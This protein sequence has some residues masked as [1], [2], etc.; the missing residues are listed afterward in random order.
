MIVLGLTGSIGMGKSTVAAMM[1]TLG[2][3]VHDSD[4]AAHRLLEPKSEAR[5]ALA[6]AFPHY[7][8]PQIYEKKTYNINRRE[9]GQIVFS[10]DE[11]R[12]RLEAI[13][14]PLVRKSQTEFLRASA[15]KGIKI[16]VLDVPLL[17]ETGADARVDY[18]ITVSA[19]AF[20]QRAR[21]L[22]RPDMTEEKFHA[23][24][25]RQMPDAEKRARSDF[26]IQTGLGRAHSLQT[27]KQILQDVQNLSGGCQE[28]TPDTNPLT[29]PI[30]R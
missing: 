30:Q 24:L 13:I 10:D 16:A 14:H 18:T 29:M 27:L 26:V 17:F 3:P 9:L 21:V 12:A 4:I 15:L 2:I 23:I 6:A 8:Y 28:K 19:P 20:L 5:L 7:E 22:A 11:A 1:K 25:A